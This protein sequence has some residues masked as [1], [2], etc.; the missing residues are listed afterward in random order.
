MEKPTNYP[1]TFMG[2]DRPSKALR[3]MIAGL[4]AAKDMPTFQINM[5]TFGTYEKKDGMYYGCAATCTLMQLTGKE[6]L[7]KEAYLESKEN[8]INY[9]KTASFI[10]KNNNSN[11]SQIWDFENAID[12][13]RSGDAE[14]ILK[15]FLLEDPKTEDREYFCM[16]SK[17]WEIEIPI[18]IALAESW[19]ADGL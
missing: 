7:V 17:D 1:V 3:A 8:N 15:F 2:I 4:L 18:A 11:E 14:Y 12:S 5:M 13:L 19:E 6:R 10:S 16:T 9:T